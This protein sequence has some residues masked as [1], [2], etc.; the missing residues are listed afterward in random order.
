M[1]EFHAVDS[2][3]DAFDKTKNLLFK[4]FKLSLWVKLAIVVI[5]TGSSLVS[6]NFNLREGGELNF[7][8]AQY[9]LI[10]VALL[11]LFIIILV[12]IEFLSSVFNFVFIESVLE[13]KVEIRNGFKRNIRRGF[14]LF[15]FKL[16]VLAIFIGIIVLGVLAALLIVDRN[17]SA[18]SMLIIM[19]TG[20]LTFLGIVLIFLLINL[21][22]TD[23]VLPIMYLKNR[24]IV[25]GWIYLKDLIKS[26][27]SQFIV[28]I[29]IKFFL[30]IVASI[31][32]LIISLIVYL[33]VIFLIIVMVVFFGVYAN[34]NT[35]D[36]L[37][38]V[39]TPLIILIFIVGII[40]FFGLTYLITF[41]TLP[42]PVFFRYYS[43]VFLN[44]IDPGQDMLKPENRDVRGNVEEN[45][46][47]Y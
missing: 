44:R 9:V 41:I 40:V 3:D 23:F 19:I 35:L 43:I 34:I 12:V 4:P 33:P 11:I 31:V 22:T 32:I 25:S 42:I 8:I 13:K 37:S 30:G 14:S 21:L 1:S 6:S 26:N 16:T 15:L 24:G 47:I 18:I 10:I 5:I 29:L 39:S 36:I 27:L 7:D 45:L 20:F 2:L 46:S 38:T 17:I 28:Y